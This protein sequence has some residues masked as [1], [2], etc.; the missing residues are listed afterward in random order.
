MS[1]PTFRERESALKGGRHS[2]SSMK[3]L[4]AK[5]PSVQWQ[6]D[7]FTIN[8]KKWFL[9][10]GFLGAPP[11]SLSLAFEPSS[12]LGSRS[13]NA[14]DCPA[15]DASC[16]IMLGCVGM[17]SKSTQVKKQHV[18]EKTTSSS[19][20]ARAP[21]RMADGPD[22][23]GIRREGSSLSPSLSLSLY[24]SHSLSISLPLSLSLSVS[25][26][27]SLSLGLSTQAAM[28]AEA[29][30]QAKTSTSEGIGH[31]RREKK[32]AA[33]K[34]ARDPPLASAAF[35][36]WPKFE[37]EISRSRN[38]SLLYDY[39]CIGASDR[40]P[41]DVAGFLPAGTAT[42]S[43]PSR[44]AALRRGLDGVHP[45]YWNPSFLLLTTSG[46]DV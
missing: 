19:I 20:C 12:C 40:G 39:Y 4:L 25:L 16:S 13:R 36:K 30:R 18:W 29:A 37:T 46:Y 21:R 8:T 2:T 45:F 10:A 32:D 34:P 15:L 27:L 7:G 35:K 17:K 41:V 9:G 1:A 5:C 31:E 43:F 14:R 22:E 11:I 26:S 23:A 42:V 38:G 44:R 6:P 33:G 28:A 24:L 3:T